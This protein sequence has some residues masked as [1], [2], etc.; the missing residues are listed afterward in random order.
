M[1]K[2]LQDNGGVIEIDNPD[3]ETRAAYRRAIHA[4]KRYSLVPAGFHLRHTGRSSGTLIIRLFDDAHPDETDW[5]RVRLGARD[6]IT[7]P[8]SLVKMLRE[9]PEVLA[10]GEA[11][12]QRALNLVRSLAEEASGRG[13][14]LA[15]SKKHKARGLYVQVGTRQY[16]IAIK[17]EQDQVVRESELQERRRR[18]R[19]SWERVPVRHESVPSGRLRVELRQPRE[20]RRDHWADT[21]TVQVDSKVSEIIKEIEHRAD[22]D[23]Q[24]A[25]ARQRQHEEW[26]AEQE[27]QEAEQRDRW[28]AAISQARSRAI[29]EYRRKIFTDAMDAWTV[30]IEIR[31][32]CAALEQAADECPHPEDAENLRSWIEWGRAYADRLD[33][34]RNPSGLARAEFDKDPSPDDLRPY[35]GDRSPHEPRKE[36]YR[37][38]REQRAQVS[39]T[40]R[41]NWWH[42][43]R[44][45]SQW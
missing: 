41:D 8:E 42:G 6:K 22:A 7:D 40:Y 11:L 3:Q 20:G 28:Q 35:L 29:D 39:D 15:M 36:Y 27:R 14:K 9:H 2:R 34:V 44:G 43:R 32:F 26:L 16:A 23:E 37:P 25:L 17:E 33:P 24:A 5:N 12:M 10:V 13:H 18:K 4:A 19:Y 21:G 30:A 1:I 38:Q 31:E 45:R